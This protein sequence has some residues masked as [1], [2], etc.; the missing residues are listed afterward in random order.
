MAMDMPPTAVVEYRVEKPAARGEGI[1]A[2]AMAFVKGGPQEVSEHVDRS[3]VIAARGLPKIDFSSKALT[4]GDREGLVVGME[5]S[6]EGRLGST[7]IRMPE[8]YVAQRLRIA[9]QADRIREAVSHD[10]TV[11]LAEARAHRCQ[12]VRTVMDRRA[13][14]YVQ[15]GEKAAAAARASLPQAAKDE[16]RGIMGQANM[17]NAGRPPKHIDPVARILERHTD[18]LASLDIL[19]PRPI[20]TPSASTRTSITPAT[21]RPQPVRIDPVATQPIRLDLKGP[22]KPMAPVAMQAF[23]MPGKGRGY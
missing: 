18:P 16:C 9:M 8:G 2:R 21:V 17:L 20:I 19:T 22:P 13:G 11:G 23:V 5:A 3:A 10:R 4:K 14:L 7:G 6:R 12:V 1:L 15:G